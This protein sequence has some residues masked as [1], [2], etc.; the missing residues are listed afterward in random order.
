MSIA[1]NPELIRA[2][3]DAIMRALTG[4][5]RVQR[6]AEGR[7]DEPD[8]DDEAAREKWAKRIIASMPDHFRKLGGA[9]FA[10]AF[11]RDV[12]QQTPINF[13]ETRR[14]W[15]QHLR[16]YAESH[17]LLPLPEDRENLK[18][19]EATPEQTG[20]TLNSKKPA[21]RNPGVAGGDPDPLRGDRDHTVREG[22]GAGGLVHERVKRFSERL[23]NPERR[24]AMKALGI[25][26]ERLKK[27]FERATE[28]QLQQLG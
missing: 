22:L 10:D 9:K 19:A 7:R 21:P 5:G 15:E 20:W 28:D 26:P 1:E 16:R 27:I 23:A 18:R 2:I 12:K 14:A 11:V 4:G 24:R 6:F 25:T 13:A 17:G 8:D 3:S